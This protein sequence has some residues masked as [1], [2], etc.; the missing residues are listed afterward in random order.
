MNSAQESRFFYHAEGHAF[1]GR[2][3]RPVCVP[4]EALA[5]IS[6]P[7]IGGHAH[8]RVD[9]F[10]IPRLVTFKAAY[11]HVTGSQPDEDED[12]YC[13]Q[14]TTTIEGIRILDFLTADRIVARLTSERKRGDKNKESH[15]LALGSTYEN[16][17]LGGYEVKVILR[18]D[19][20]LRCKTYADLAK[21]VASDEKSGKIAHTSGG[22]TVCSLVERIETDFPGLDKTKHVLDIP[23]F[24]IISLAEIYAEPSRRVITMLGLKLGSPDGATLVAA[25][26]S[27]NGQTWP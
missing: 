8:T 6:L 4:I 1:S 23:H 18:H 27:S 9:N 12:T 11:S 3:H 2:F 17:R 14:V 26:A 15:I 25:Q 7:T 22:A 13:T 10:H 24:G 19:L 5:S 16:L 20:F 21:E